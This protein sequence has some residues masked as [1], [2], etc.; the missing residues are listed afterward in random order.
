M[1][2]VYQSKIKTGPSPDPEIDEAPRS[3][4]LDAFVGKRIRGCKHIR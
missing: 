4:G 1:L 2:E 3:A